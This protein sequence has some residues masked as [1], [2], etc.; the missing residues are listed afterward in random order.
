MIHFRRLVPK[1]F[2]KEKLVPYRSG[3]RRLKSTLI[4]E[5]DI[6]EVVQ[7]HHTPVLLKETIRELLHVDEGVYI[8][9]TLGLGGHTLEILRN[10]N[11]AKVVSLD[12][13][14]EVI[15][16][17]C[18]NPEL[19]KYMDS[20]RF[21]PVH[22]QFSKIGQVVIDKEL[23]NINGILMDIGV[24]SMQ[25]DNAERGFSY[26]EENDGP[27]DMRMD[28]SQN[29]SAYNIVNEYSQKHLRDIIREYGD[30]P[31]ASLVAAKIVN[32]RTNGKILTTKQLADL[33][34]STMPRSA[35]PKQVLKRIKRTFQALRIEVNGEYDELKAALSTSESL[36]AREGRL[37]IISF[38]SGEDAI[39]KK[40]VKIT[41]DPRKIQLRKSVN[42]EVKLLPSFYLQSNKPLVPK[43]E[44]IKENK[45]SK[46]AIM[47]VIARTSNPSLTEQLKSYNTNLNELL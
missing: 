18:S 28:R 24:S 20:G 32:E 38:H 42:R 36:L 17:A 5:D 26:R 13:D 30:E 4:D 21:T 9:C 31:A 29:L 43:E 15:D 6:D 45:R 35:T 11:V 37:G 8:D 10:T 14:R 27:L 34:R 47:R 2:L 12:R 1:Q 46:S 44:E 33:L 41:T 16:M 22:S 19:K 40:F 39:S 25:I 7:F 23:T 3:N